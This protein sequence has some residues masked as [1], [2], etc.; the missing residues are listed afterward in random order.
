MVTDTYNDDIFG[1]SNADEEI[2]QQK[3]EIGKVWEIKDVRET[4][5]FL[6]M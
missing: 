4:E 1:A 5:Y 2:E 3:G 6:G